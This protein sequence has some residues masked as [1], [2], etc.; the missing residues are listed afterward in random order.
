MPARIDPKKPWNGVMPS[1][2]SAVEFKVYVWNIK[3]NA[4][5]WYP[6]IRYSNHFAP[7]PP[8]IWFS[9]DGRYLY[10]NVCSQTHLCFFSPQLCFVTN[11]C[12][13]RVILIALQ[14]VNGFNV[15][16]LNHLYPNMVVHLHMILN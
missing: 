16:V 14:I 5:Q 3:T 9:Y 10:Y 11:L 4:C 8:L 7:S 2:V 12:L 15:I 6:M 13:C 1:T